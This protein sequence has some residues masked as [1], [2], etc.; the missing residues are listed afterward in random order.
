MQQV[1]D[2]LLGAHSL[3]TAVQADLC[4]SLLP[5]VGHGT[6]IHAV[7]PTPSKPSAVVVER[8]KRRDVMIA[9]T[10]TP[11]PAKPLVPVSLPLSKL[12]NLDIRQ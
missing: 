5:C 10:F 9:I 12:T 4:A 6:A 7:D 8:C 3:L 11:I 2:L 1:V